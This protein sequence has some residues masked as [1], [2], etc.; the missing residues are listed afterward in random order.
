MERK[1]TLLFINAR[2]GMEK[3]GSESYRIM[4]ALCRQGCELTV[5]P[6]L[7]TV[8]ELSIDSILSGNAGRFELVSCVGGDGTLHHLVNALMKE[9]ERMPILYFPFG[10]TNDFA[11]SL[12]IPASVTRNAASVTRGSL[13]PCDIGSLN[14]KYFSYV[15]AFGSFTKV[16]Y[17]TK[18]DLKNVLGYPA[19][20]L[21]GLQTLPENLNYS[22][23]L[24]ILHD[25]EVEEG[26]FLFGA[27]S[28]TSSIGGFSAFG[29]SA[30]KQ[31]PSPAL[32]DGLFEVLLIRAP[33]NIQELTEI[34]GSLVSAQ[35]D[36]DSPYI[37][38]FKS[39]EL[40]IE[41][42]RSIEWT[43]DGEYGG[44]FRRAEIRNHPKSIR[45]LLPAESGGAEKGG[46]KRR[47]ADG[48]GKGTERKAALN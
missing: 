48:R 43:L 35:M 8:P 3:G 38:A 18:Q 31:K 33:K 13:F 1:K 24:K 22:R 10:S 9:E 4:E 2:A 34:I 37:R 7:P 29:S 20:L 11:R 15:A 39:A 14:G 5:Y 23:R 17:S 47:S 41:S 28:N 19:Y 42:E 46:G 12:G 21:H 36:R 26:D 45:I 6:V 40:L 44:K 16:S 32:N 27:V 30:L 25:G